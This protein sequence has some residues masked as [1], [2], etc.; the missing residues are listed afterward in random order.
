MTFE[1]E[2]VIKKAMF[3]NH[4][5]LY[6]TEWVGSVR[7]NGINFKFSIDNNGYGRLSEK[8]G[9]I[10]N[11]D[12]FFDNNEIAFHI[13]KDHVHNPSLAIKY[14]FENIDNVKEYFQKAYAVKYKN[15]IDNLYA[16]V[17]ENSMNLD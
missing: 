6:G 16:N 3:S 15:L 8:D 14:S 13:D 10:H 5:I 17:M 2:N 12:S 1:F 11:P 7:V 4:G 9:F